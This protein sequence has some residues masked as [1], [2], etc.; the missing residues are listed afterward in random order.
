MYYN[1][2]NSSNNRYRLSLVT[3]PL[4]FPVTLQEVKDFL[5]ITSTDEDNLLNNYIAVATGNAESYTRRAFITQTWQMFMDQ[6]PCQDKDMWWDGVKQLPISTL[7]ESNGF[8]IPKPPLQSVT[9]FKTYDDNDVASIF[10]TSSYQV[11]VYSGDYAENGRITLRDSGTYP[12]YTRNADGI[13][14]EFICGYGDNADD[15]PWQIKQGILQEISY[16]YQH[17]EEC[18]S[19]GMNCCVARGLLEPFRIIKL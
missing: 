18:G 1:R 5:R 7:V 15:V 8:Y 11:S 16:M 13:E 12:E 19:D 9:H 17:R 3:A 2:C 6:Y 10:S 4:I 14:I